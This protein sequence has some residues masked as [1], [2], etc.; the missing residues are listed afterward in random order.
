MNDLRRKN[1][2]RTPQPPEKKRK[3]ERK[4]QAETRVGRHSAIGGDREGRTQ[5]TKKPRNVPM[6]SDDDDGS[7][8]R[9]R[10]GCRFVRFFKHFCSLLLRVVVVGFV[11]L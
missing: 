5:R 8:Y 4:N 3:K 9:G 6:I 1:P 10:I 7:V 2:I 11:G